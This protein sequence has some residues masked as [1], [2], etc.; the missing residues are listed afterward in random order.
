MVSEMTGRIV[1]MAWETSDTIENVHEM[2]NDRTKNAEIGKH[3]IEAV[4][5]SKSFEIAKKEIGVWIQTDDIV[6]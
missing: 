3:I 6:L 1:T 5:I 4:H 2:L